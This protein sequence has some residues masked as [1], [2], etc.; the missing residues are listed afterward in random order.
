MFSSGGGTL[1][2]V[3]FTWKQLQGLRVARPCLLSPAERQEGGALVDVS[4]QGLGLKLE[5]SGTGVR[6]H[7]EVKGRW[8]WL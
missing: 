1:D 6:L 7:Q 4:P 8:A 3:C 2:G 5:E